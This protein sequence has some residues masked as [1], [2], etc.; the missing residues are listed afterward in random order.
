MAEDVEEIVIPAEGQMDPRVVDLP[1]FHDQNAGFLKITYKTHE[2]AKKAMKKFLSCYNK[3]IFQSSCFSVNF[4]GFGEEDHE[5]KKKIKKEIKLENKMNPDVL[6]AD[7]DDAWAGVKE[8]KTVSECSYPATPKYGYYGSEATSKA[9]STIG[10]VSDS[11]ESDIPKK[12]AKL[13]NGLETY[14]Y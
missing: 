6:V 1:R 7:D 8:F 14:D 9:G 13:G 12:R 10:Q 2:A 4:D 3:S 5:R 11:D